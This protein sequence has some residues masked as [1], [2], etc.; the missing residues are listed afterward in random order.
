MRRARL[1]L[2]AACAAAALPAA[3]L[4]LADAFDPS[5]PLVVAVGEPPGA[6]PAPRVDESRTGRARAPLPEHPTETWRRELGG[7]ID[8]APVVDAEGAVVAALATGEVVRIAADGTERWRQRLGAP[9]SV[10]PVLT[11]DG[12]VVL[13][14]GAGDVVGIAPHG[15]LVFRAPLALRA[16]DLD[17]T[18]IP[19]DD[20]G[21]AFAAGR[22]LVAVG[23][24]GAVRARAEAPARVSG[25]LLGGPEGVVFTTDDGDAYAWRAPAAPRLLGHFGGPVRHGAVRA[26]ARA[27]AAVVDGRAI[28]VLDV[29]T[30]TT[31]V[32]ASAA[33]GDAFDAPVAVGA[34]GTSFV[35]T[36]TGT[37]VAIQ[38]NGDM[39]A[40]AALERTHAA[41][42]GDAGFFPAPA[43]GASP[44]VLVDAEE[45]VAFVRSEGRA[46]IV[47][48]GGRVSV[49]SP[50]VCRNPVAL[51]PAGAR[52]VVV[53]C[54]DG[55]IVRLG[56]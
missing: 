11:T 1:V 4:A 30:G 12:R 14:D 2:V 50:R 8:V 3:S 13:A 15:A 25:A 6:A 22:A 51:L 5:R 10:P 53:A 41:A 27:L 46:G 37:L 23:R 24:D 56:D 52:A 43:Q 54:R 19:L 36:S 44:P 48:A 49:A 45:R 32:L 40:R 21:V 42:F 35:A 39:A 34:N 18:P 20:G 29:P 33:P 7:G 38:P 47:D 28:V 55:A 9:A 26:S 17:V 16:R 31:H